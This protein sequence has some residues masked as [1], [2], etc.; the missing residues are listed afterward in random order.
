MKYFNKGTGY[1]ITIVVLVILNV[2]LLFSFWYKEKPDRHFGKRTPPPGKEARMG[3]LFEK[4]LGLNAAQKKQYKTLREAHFEYARNAKREI[5]DLRNDLFLQIH[6]GEE[7]AKADSIA[8]L[9]GKKEGA[10][11]KETFYHFRQ[12]RAICSDEQKPKF[13]QLMKNVLRRMDRH[14]HPKRKKRRSHKQH[15]AREAH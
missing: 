2:A 10:L 7:T 6:N 12:L 8:T 4:K 1:I 3:H 11:E 9:I 5:H 14:G 13:D 15:R